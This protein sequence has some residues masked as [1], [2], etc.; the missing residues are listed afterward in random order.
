MRR[1]H[2]RRLRAQEGRESLRGRA[3][4]ARSV[5]GLRKGHRSEDVWGVGRGQLRAALRAQVRAGVWDDPGGAE[6]EFW[7]GDLEGRDDIDDFDSW[8][9]LLPDTETCAH[10]DYCASVLA[11][12]GQESEGSTRVTASDCDDDSTVLSSG[13]EERSC[14]AAYIS[15]SSSSI[16][17]DAKGPFEDPRCSR[18]RERVTRWG[19]AVARANR[20]AS[21]FSRPLNCTCVPQGRKKHGR[22]RP[23]EDLSFERIRHEFLGKNMPLL[24]EAFGRI[25]RS[26]TFSAA[27]ISAPL[28]SCFMEAYRGMKEKALCP[29]YHG[30]HEQK[31]P[32]I[33]SSGLLIPGDGNDVK[34]A[35]GTAYGRGIYAATVDNPSVSLGFSRPTMDC[36]LLCALLDPGSKKD[37]PAVSQYSG[38]VV[39]R[40]PGCV[41]PLYEARTAP[42][43]TPD[44]KPQPAARSAPERGAQPPRRGRRG[45]KTVPAAALPGRLASALSFLS[46]R[47]AAKRRT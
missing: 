23:A 44:P 7:E 17:D 10:N 12:D 25:G 38:F 29:V 26:V 3:A 41:F 8:S 43:R 19:I 5:N 13:A 6:A 33:F 31:F 30:T 46:R 20:I 11:P 37:D 21:E 24:K 35:N 1:G 22:R 36:V 32:S 9:R 14:D 34:V 45:R 47:A 42:Q 2:C 28:K 15:G 39:V 27:P 16:L 18:A 40:K 4:F